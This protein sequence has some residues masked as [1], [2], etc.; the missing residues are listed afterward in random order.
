MALIH[1]A[2]AIKDLLQE[3]VERGTQLVENIH[4]LIEDTVVETAGVEDNEV[5]TAHRERVAKVYEA[6]RSLNRQFGEAASDFFAAIED[7][8]KVDAVLKDKEGP[9]S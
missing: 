8:A 1:Q 4:R 3:S 7:Q 6:I 9:L 2:E 5:V